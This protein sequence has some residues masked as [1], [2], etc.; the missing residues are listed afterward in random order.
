MML[1]TLIYS[2][3]EPC[4]QPCDSSDH[5]AIY[6]YT[7]QLA[8]VNFF[9]CIQQLYIRQNLFSF[10][11]KIAICIAFLAFGNYTINSLMSDIIH[12]EFKMNWQK[13]LYDV[14]RKKQISK[15]K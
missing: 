8:S 14:G 9:L 10:C 5:T 11:N 1:G 2:N 6:I 4:T 12:I 7:F 13:V 15:L 3:Q